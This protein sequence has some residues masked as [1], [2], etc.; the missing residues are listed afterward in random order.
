[1][2]FCDRFPRVEFCCFC[3]ELPFGCFLASITMIIIN[4]L[5]ISFSLN[6]LIT[7]TGHFDAEFR[8]LITS[9]TF[10][11][12]DLILSGYLAFLI[13]RWRY[14]KL[15]RYLWLKGALLV[16]DVLF[17]ILLTV[18]VG[19]LAGAFSLVWL[20]AMTLFWISVQSLYNEKRFA[21]NLGRVRDTV[22]KA[23]A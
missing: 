13:H 16:L 9:G 23:F 12:L 2:T 11:F 20:L 8:T 5:T 15:L 18:N 10:D 14:L 21:P 7:K 1:M 22:E 3:F 4:I 6:R 19:S 17:V